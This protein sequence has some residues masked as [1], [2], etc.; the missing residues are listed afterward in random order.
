MH[1]LVFQHQIE[2]AVTNFR[3]VLQVERYTSYKGKLIVV[4]MLSVGSVWCWITCA[5]HPNKFWTS[6]GILTLLSCQPLPWLKWYLTLNTYLALYMQITVY[7]VFIFGTAINLCTNSDWVISSIWPES[8]LIILHYCI[9]CNF[10]I[11][12][13]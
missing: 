11:K 8:E 13:Y 3:N 12:Y 7:N 9:L 4:V 6:S 1:W 5:I 2:T 10:K